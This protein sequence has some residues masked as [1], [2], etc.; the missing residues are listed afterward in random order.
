[1]SASRTQPRTL[2]SSPTDILLSSGAIPRAASSPREQPAQP[3]R[4]S[5]TFIFT[6]PGLTWVAFN[7]DSSGSAG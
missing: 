3:D 5:R 2:D 4:Y 6:P 7:R 1:M